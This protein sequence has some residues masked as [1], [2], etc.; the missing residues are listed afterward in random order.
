MAA[1][2]RAP[3]ASE[4]PGAAR[5]SQPGGFLSLIRGIAWMI[6]F[7]ACCLTI[8][9][10]QVLG[11]PLYLISKDWYYAYMA[12]TK[13]SLGLTLA[14]MTQI[15]SPNTVRISG[16]ASV[17]GEIEPTEDG[18][19]RF[20]FPERTILFANHQIDTDWLYLWWIAYANRPSMHG[21]IYIILKETLKWLPFLGW[22][23]QFFS[24]IFLA[25]KMATDR[26]RLAYRL[27]KLKREHVD[28][29]GNKYMEPMWL[30]LFPEGTNASSN[31]RKRSVAYANKMGLK[32]PDHMLLPRSTG[33]YFCLKELEGTVEYIYDAT[34]AYEGIPRGK[35]GEDFF[36][37]HKTFVNGRG[38]KSINFYWRRFR[39]A[40]LPLDDQEKFDVWLREQWY[41]K[42]A[43]M[44]DYLTTGRFP[45]MEGK[46][47]YV[48]TIVR[49]RQPW[50]ILQ[51]FTVVGICSLIWHNLTKAWLTAGRL[52]GKQ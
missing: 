30:L 5:A 38:P 4:K 22:G 34:V 3:G 28:P 18:G 50:E 9:F 6:F 37:L 47:D 52:V 33:I 12:M 45:P 43:L 8:N 39:V 51:V 16:D 49:T 35:Y 46:L 13:R 17:A 24:F 19:V 40:D 27:N 26:D 48:E 7:T 1:E 20:N 29:R 10:T 36:T 41:I 32:D 31:T 23:M 21:H 2:T 44:D 15:W 25:R 11:T 42:D 14:F